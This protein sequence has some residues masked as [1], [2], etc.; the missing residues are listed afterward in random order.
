MFTKDFI[1]DGGSDVWGR[2]SLSRHQLTRNIYISHS[3]QYTSAPREES[4]RKIV[5]N[6]P[7]VPKKKQFFRRGHERL[8]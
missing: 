2:R 5:G 6:M 1:S 7:K 4:S 8:S 3:A